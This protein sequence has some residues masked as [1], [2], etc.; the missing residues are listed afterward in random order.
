MAV[1][2]RLVKTKKDLK[3]F[4]KLPWK[5]YEKIPNW[6]PGLIF[7]LYDKLNRNK[8][9]FF[10]HATADY[11]LA[12]RD[13]EVVGRI[14]ALIDHNHNEYYTR[15]GHVEKTGFWGLFE[16]IDDQEVADALFD[17]AKDWNKRRDMNLF[18]GPMSFGTNDELGMLIE[19]YEYH[20]VF[21]NT[22][23]P[24]YYIGLCEKYG[25][26]KAKDLISY[27]EDLSKDV[28]PRVASIA[29]GVKKRSEKSGIRIRTMDPKNK[30]R[31]I[32]LA[33]QIYEEAWKDNWGFVPMT[34]KEFEKNAAS[35]ITLITKRPLVIFLE[36][37]GKTIGVSV[38][39][40]DINKLNNELLQKTR[41]YPIWFQG[42]LQYINIALKII[43]PRR[44]RCEW[45]R[46]I[47]A[48][49]LPDYRQRGIDVFLYTVPYQNAQSLG[50]THGD[51][52]WELEDNEAINKALQK[53][54][55]VVYKRHRI[56]DMKI[57]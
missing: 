4:I 21:M 23:S 37:N 40:Y 29:E 27:F 6:T 3:K 31:D 57:K 20:N 15:D 14:A 9:P 35:G 54:G 28:P 42:L 11:F 36:D 17:A 12:I 39:L 22:Y 25:M 49:L 19:G 32:G 41:Y 16:C 50:L 10:E 46:L 55:G 2:I 34:K 43:L 7:D 44:G 13:D 38:A 5:I 52:S 53:L 33:F 24:P 56:W 47:I 48:G 30:K 1:E 8:N 45:V 51:M 18:R 26:K